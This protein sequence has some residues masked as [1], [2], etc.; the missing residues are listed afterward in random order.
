M[1]K[2]TLAI[3]TLVIAVC[4]GVWFA[5]S[6]AGK[7]SDC[8]PLGAGACVRVAIP[9]DTAD[10]PASCIKGEM[11]LKLTSGAGN[12]TTANNNSLCLCTAANTWTA[13]NNN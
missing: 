8:L 7:Y 11:Y 6:W 9:A 12:C 4:V 13:L 3:W 10:P 1:S 2:T 5:P